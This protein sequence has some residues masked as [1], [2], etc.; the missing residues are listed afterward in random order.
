MSVP[1]STQSDSLNFAADSAPPEQSSA[2]L[3]P[4]IQALGITRKSIRLSRRESIITNSKYESII[5]DYQTHRKPEVVT[6]EGGR[7]EPAFR[8]FN[9][10]FSDLEEHACYKELLN[11]EPNKIILNKTIEECKIE[12]FNMPYVDTLPIED[13]FEFVAQRLITNR[14]VAPS[15]NPIHVLTVSSETQF[16]D[17]DLEQHDLYEELLI[18]TDQDKT[19]LNE[20]IAKCKTDYFNKPTANTRSL[21]DFFEYVASRF[22]AESSP[23]QVSDLAIEPSS[24]LSESSRADSTDTRDLED[25]ALRIARDSDSDL[26]LLS[27]VE[28]VVNGTVSLTTEDWQTVTENLRK[29]APHLPKFIKPDPNSMKATTIEENR[30][31]YTYTTAGQQHSFTIEYGQDNEPISVTF[32]NPNHFV[33]L[34]SNLFDASVH[35]MGNVLTG[36]LL[37]RNPLELT[38]TA[39]QGETHF[40]LR[41]ESGK[42]VDNIKLYVKIPIVG[43]KGIR[44]KLQAQQN[45]SGKITPTSIEF[46]KNS[47]VISPI[48][49]DQIIDRVNLQKKE[50]QEVDKWAKA[51]NLRADIEQIGFTSGARIQFSMNGSMNGS[52][53]SIPFHLQTDFK[54]LLSDG[55]DW[56]NAFKDLSW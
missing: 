29:I 11:I 42:T 40:N 50:K 45:I 41:Y 38:L 24:V 2:E 32:Q 10:Y 26:Q 22:N 9:D 56:Q 23:S 44:V 46:D 48:K 52:T 36:R 51:K 14:T 39:S 17:I 5:R 6:E 49:P 25:L 31:E 21:V 16:D 33:P 12:Y 35:G 13:F 34:L 20:F 4:D 47:L 54:G 27:E 43:E 7:I 15:T 18:F 30:T 3:L 19:Q 53:D 37:G 28:N 55:A 1:N 8:V